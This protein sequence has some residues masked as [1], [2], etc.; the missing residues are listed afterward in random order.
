MMKRL[1]VLSCVDTLKSVEL[2]PSVWC[3]PNRSSPPG[4]RAAITG[5]DVLLDC[6]IRA[7]GNA[8]VTAPRNKRRSIFCILG[9]LLF[10]T[11]LPVEEVTTCGSRLALSQASILLNY[12]PNSL[13]SLGGP[14]FAGSQRHRRTR[15]PKQQQKKKWPP[16]RSAYSL[17]GS[18]TPG[19]ISVF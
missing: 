4:T 5:V 18:C 8:A 11:N 1:P 17:L 15:W 2:T 7:N 12:T 6:P 9:I 16:A 10:L 19:R 13:R 14:I 3:S